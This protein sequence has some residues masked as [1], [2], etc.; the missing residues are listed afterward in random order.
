LKEGILRKFGTEKK[1]KIINGDYHSGSSNK[2]EKEGLQLRTPRLTL[3]QRE[4]WNEKRR[5]CREIFIGLIVMR[6][7]QSEKEIEGEGFL[8]DEYYNHYH[9][10][11]YY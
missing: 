11:C 5:E 10:Y 4:K 2:D 7:I 8:L 6:L 1:E 9:Y 3:N